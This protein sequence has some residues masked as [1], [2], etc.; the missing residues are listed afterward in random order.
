M[1]VLLKLTLD[2]E[3]ETAWQRIQ[4]PAMLQAV[5]APIMTVYSL[6]PDGF[7]A[8]WTDS[9]HR[10][11]LRLFGLIPFGKQLVL[12]S[13]RIGHGSGVN[14]LRDTG[15]AY[16]GPLSLLKNWDHRMAISALPDGRAL[17]RDQLRVNAGLLTPLAWPAIWLMWQARG[18]KIQ[19]LARDW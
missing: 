17:F 2:C 7:R 8:E 5:S 6:E 12:V 9:P 10:I 15:G 1:R 13:R 3:P 4:Q 19:R 16:T 14:I 11:A 18:A